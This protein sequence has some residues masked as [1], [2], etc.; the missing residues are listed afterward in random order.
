MSSASLAGSDPNV[1]WHHAA[2]CRLALPLRPP[3]PEGWSREADGTLVQLEPLSPR[4]PEPAAGEDGAS[5]PVAEELLL[6]AGR[7]LRLVLIHLFSAALAGGGSQVELGAGPEAI[8][9]RF[10]LEASEQRVRELRDAADRLFS[11]RLRLV[12]GLPPGVAML[13]ARAKAKVDAQGWRPTLR[14]SE[15][16]LTQL[17]KQAV[18]LDVRAVGRLAGSV[19]AL[20]AYVW[21]AATLPGVAE[22]Q[23]ALHGWDTL[24]ERF[25]DG[26][27]MPA[28]FQDAFSASLAAA[29][30]AYPDA[31]FGVGEA[32][33]ELH[34]S[35]SPVPGLMP[36]PAPRPRPRRARPEPVAPEAL[37]APEAVPVSAPGPLPDAA[38]VDAGPAVAA[39]GDGIEQAMADSDVEDMRQSTYSSVETMAEPDASG[40]VARAPRT[41]AQP[42]APVQAPA[43][44]RTES[45]GRRE[46]RPD[47]R[48]AL[49]PSLTGLPMTVW[50]RRGD[51]GELMAIEVTPGGEYDLRRRAVL[52]LEPILLQVS[53]QLHPRELDRVAAWAVANAD[54]IQDV[55]DGSLPMP[56]ALQQVRGLPPGRW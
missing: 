26:D 16:F 20:D 44:E 49:S 34:R 29:H 27:P 48:V 37:P 11:A 55:W 53:G 40:R 38:P 24:Y 42:T 32:G 14:L 22:D 31:V 50:L 7:G 21:L 47:G 2:I 13:D 25:A 46:P 18:P 33:V 6:P 30:E 12:E 56:S 54:L 17:K 3:T 43:R 35:P 23:P 41:P 9:E 10:G 8:I 28:R 4:G 51:R 1:A 39:S 45:G 36:P 52:A 5:G 19:P 15:R